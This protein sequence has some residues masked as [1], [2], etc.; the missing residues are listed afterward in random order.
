MRTLRHVLWIG[1]PPGGGKSTVA[2]RIARRHGLRRYSADTRTWRHRDRALRAGSEAARRWEA[3]TPERRW[4]G[5]TPHEQLEGSLHRERGPMVVDDLGALPGS[6]LVVAEGSPL[7]AWALSSGIAER[8]RAVW[9]LPT[10]Q[11]Q[12]AVMAGRGLA[13]GPTALY[14]LLGE[15]IE[16]EA[17]EHRA[18]TLTVDGSRDVR[19]VAAAVEELFAD[20]LAEGPRAGTLGERRSLLREMNQATADQVRGFYARPW[21]H[22]DAEA[23]AQPF[24]C[25]CG[26]PACDASVLVPLRELSSGAVLGAGQQ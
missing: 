20:V 26:D 22:G 5:S 1:G 14:L 21:A 25:E 16:R 24:V 2:T 7:P 23:V 11:F 9:L 19:Q 12:Q 15:T 13:P 10:R 4:A 6:P 18:R 17:M 8:S 3:M